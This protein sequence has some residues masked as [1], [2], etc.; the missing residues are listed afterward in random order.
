MEIWMIEVRFFCLLLVDKK[1]LTLS[2]LFY[3]KRG[4]LVGCKNTK[5]LISDNVLKKILF[6]Q[7]L[8]LL[9]KQIDHDIRHL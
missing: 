3:G 4:K 9:S 5:I 6:Q 8:M 2:A 1:R 7:S